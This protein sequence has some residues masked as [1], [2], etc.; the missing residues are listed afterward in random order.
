MRLGPARR[1]TPRALWVRPLSP[2]SRLWA[3]RPR[4]GCGVAARRVD[5]HGRDLVGPSR[6]PRGV[7]VLPRVT[8]QTEA[9]AP[10]LLP[11]PVEPEAQVTSSQEPPLTP[12]CPTGHSPVH[13]ATTQA[14]EIARR[15]LPEPGGPAPGLCPQGRGLW[16]RG[17]GVWRQLGRVC[18]GSGRG[19]LPMAPARHKRFPSDFCL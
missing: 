12:G 13:T 9:R 10:R 11:Q 18:S 2:A 7:P 16:G 14:L 15:V 8:E 5:H 6:P 3:P 4:G 17:R 1:H 19:R